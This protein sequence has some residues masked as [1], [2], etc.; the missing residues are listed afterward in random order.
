M[1]GGG[2]VC[3]FVKDTAGAR[4]RL[5]VLME[6]G[7][8][9]TLAPARIITQTKLSG[10]SEG[11]SLEELVEKT[12]EKRR[13]LALEVD[14]ESL[15]E[16][17]EGE[18]PKL[19][20]E[21]L[22]SLYFGREAEADA[23]SAL[24]RAIHAD[25]LWFEFSPE[26]AR[27]RD[28]EEVEKVRTIRIREAAKKAVKE[29]G[30]AWIAAALE[31]SEA[32]TKDIGASEIGAGSAEENEFGAK[33]PG[34][35]GES[36]PAQRVSG[37]SSAFEGPLRA[38]GKSG[39]PKP[40]EAEAVISGLKG[41]LMS[42]DDFKEAG[43]AKEI[44]RLSGLSPD[45]YGAFRALRAVGEISQD[46]H[47]EL[48]RLGR[49]L[50]FSPAVLKEAEL[51]VSGFDLG[52][53]SRLDLS[54]LFTVTVDAPGAREF[55]D[56]MSLETL[57]DGKKIVWLHIADPA[58][59]VLKGAPVDAAAA[60]RAATVYLP[61]TRYPMLPEVLTESVMSL[62][63]GETRPAFSLKVELSPSG[64]PEAFSFY[65]SLVSVD[66][67]L[68][69]SEAEERLS[70]EGEK[71]ALAPLL[72]VARVLSSRRSALGGQ[73][74]KLPRGNVR[75]DSQG[76]PEAFLVDVESS[77][78]LMVEEMMILANHLAARTLK[79]AGWPCPYRYQEKSL[80]RQWAP[81]PEASARVR[82]AADLAARR[83]VG[84]GGVTL[85]PS[86]HHGG[87]LGAYTSF[88]SPMRRYLDLAVARQLR[89]LSS[90]GPPAYDH[91]SMMSLAMDFEA[92]YKAIRRLQNNRQRYWLLRLLAGKIGERFV[93]L[94]FERRGRKGKVCLTEYMLELELPS[95]PSEAE[96]GTDVLLRLLFAEPQILDRKETLIFEFLQIL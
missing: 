84:R 35:P 65:P 11:A 74:L 16:S 22:A 94:V 32:E 77:A 44:L 26:S 12:S 76:L 33:G 79:D 73:S 37:R 61:E 53:E 23:V 31:E 81:P 68:S 39:A 70:S 83:L 62:V 13:K 2:L 87:G 93:G 42:G 47:V 4:G 25:G 43:Q 80:P 71:S 18:E 52:I 92:D 6:G 27:R 19:G 66:L 17:L 60:A 86:P 89:A 82:L 46:E 7:K 45:A 91:E 78:G 28:A 24:I 40:A 15:W 69:F 9:I 85:E 8:T 50:D 49:P 72:S 63:K 30:A 29:K 3:G 58:A 38:G 51:L 34:E 88:T 96:P 14:L 64:E 56:A 10:R 20:Y 48:A 95:L 5:V 21:L 57:P 75:L 41:L 90:G 59:L 36:D 54:G 55:D 1:E 67:Q